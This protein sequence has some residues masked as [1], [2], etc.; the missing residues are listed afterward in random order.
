MKTKSLFP[1]LGLILG[2]AA[3]DPGGARPGRPEAYTRGIGSGAS[4]TAADAR[5]E[6]ALSW[7]RP[8]RPEAW[9]R[10]IGRE[11]ARTFRT[12]DM[13]ACPEAMPGRPEGY[14]RGIHPGGNDPGRIRCA[15]L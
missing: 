5:S 13:R 1:V 8:G 9:T 2:T 3:A 4:Y 7:A 12:R 6:E 15:M 10:G 14:T 11:D